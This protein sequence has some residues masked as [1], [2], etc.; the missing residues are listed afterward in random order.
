[1]LNEHCRV[2]ESSKLGPDLKNGG[3]GIELENK[4]YECHSKQHS[5]QMPRL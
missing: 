1:M 4:M 3:L 2:N 5:G